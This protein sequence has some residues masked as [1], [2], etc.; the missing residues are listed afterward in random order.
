MKIK[1]VTEDGILF[2]DGS[3]ITC[4][5]TD[6][7]SYS[8]NYADFKHLDDTALDVDFPKELVFESVQGSG[9]RFGF[10]NTM[11]FIPCYSEQNGYYDDNVDVFYNGEIK[12]KQ[13]GSE[14]KYGGF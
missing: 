8:Y 14:I 2:D 10:G 11:F 4:E 3:I 6:P 7:G 13:L 1:S 5:Q 9:F 12:I